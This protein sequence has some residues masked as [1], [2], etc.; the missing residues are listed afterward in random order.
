MATYVAGERLIWNFPGRERG[1]IEVIYQRKYPNP[2]HHYVQD[3]VE[4]RECLAQVTHLTQ[5]NPFDLN[6][7]D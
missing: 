6:E 4:G 3:V 5:I 1:P 2:F 7:V